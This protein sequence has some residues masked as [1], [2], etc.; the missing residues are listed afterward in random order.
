MTMFAAAA[1][2]AASLCVLNNAIERKADAMAMLY[3]RQRPAYEGASSI[4]AWATVFEGAPS[5]HISRI[6]LSTHLPTHLPKS[7]NL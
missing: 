7:P 4:G 3:G 2:W 5:R 6:S 1:P